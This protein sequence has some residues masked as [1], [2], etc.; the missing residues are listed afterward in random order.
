M[1]EYFFLKIGSI[2]KESNIK[3]RLIIYKI[4]NIFIYIFNNISHIYIFLKNKILRIEKKGYY[5]SFDEY[6][7]IFCTTNE[8]YFFEEKN[9]STTDGKRKNNIKNYNNKTKEKQIKKINNN[10]RD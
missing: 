8:N 7:E 5:F 9:E 4:Y 2:S 6:K 10:I 3:N 1:E